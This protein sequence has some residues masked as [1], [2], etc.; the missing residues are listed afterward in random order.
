MS[1]GRI[2]RFAGL[3]AILT[4]TGCVDRKFVI[5]SNIPNAQVY[6]DN[7]SIG[8]APA[9]SPFEYYGYYTSIWFRPHRHEPT[10]F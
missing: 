8:A 1:R 3:L 10:T 6:I 9:Y 2:I 7:K 4:A 5:E